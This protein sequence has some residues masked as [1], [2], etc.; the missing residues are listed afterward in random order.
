MAQSKKRTH[1]PLAESLAGLIK[2]MIVTEMFQIDPDLTLKHFDDLLGNR[3]LYSG[4]QVRLFFES[5]VRSF[6]EKLKFTLFPDEVLCDDLVGPEYDC[7]YVGLEGKRVFQIS[8]GPFDNLNGKERVE[9]C[10]LFNKTINDPCLMTFSDFYNLTGIDF[11]VASSNITQ[12]RSKYFS[13]FHTPNFPVVDAVSISMNFPIVFR[14][15]YI[16]FPV[17]PGASDEYNDAYK[18]LWVDG[19]IFNNLPIH[20]FDSLPSN[21][22]EVTYLGTTIYEYLASNSFDEL[23]FFTETEPTGF[24][25]NVFGLAIGDRR[26]L[27]ETANYENLFG[28]LA[29]DESPLSSGIGKLGGDLFASFLFSG[30]TGRLKGVPNTNYKHLDIDITKDEKNIVFRGPT[31]DDGVFYNSDYEYEL[32]LLDFATPEL[33]RKRAKKITGSNISNKDRQIRL[34]LTKQALLK[35]VLINKAH[36]TVYDKI[37]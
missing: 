31:P 30:S 11:V 32:P 19:G 15:L 25:K 13:V 2:S 7:N 37:I 18:G 21:L 27:A 16:N 8:R 22:E 14:P 24:N 36:K 35:D 26:N 5:Q 29:E 28:P 6:A 33:L 20:A 17:K 9:I 23:P 12:R 4:F 10:T 1:Y 34:E 3:G